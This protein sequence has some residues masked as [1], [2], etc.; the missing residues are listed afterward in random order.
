M[1]S[2]S[3]N[4]STLAVLQCHRLEILFGQHQFVLLC[5][6]KSGTRTDNLI[7]QDNGTQRKL[8][9]PCGICVATSYT[10]VKHHEIPLCI[11]MTFEWSHEVSVPFSDIDV[12]ICR[13]YPIS[14][15]RKSGSVCRTS[16][17]PEIQYITAYW[18]INPHVFISRWF[19]KL[20]LT[21][22]CPGF[23]YWVGIGGMH[24]V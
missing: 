13:W 5:W 2:S 7:N 15:Y 20:R 11:W 24:K 17:T 6:F 16:T 10:R 21:E 9:S 23:C 14:P 8:G 1:G 18:Q 4:V 12:A 19:I 22:I 3:T